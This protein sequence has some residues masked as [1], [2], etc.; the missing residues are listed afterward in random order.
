MLNLVVADRTPPGVFRIIHLQL[1]L[2]MDEKTNIVFEAIT[3]RNIRMNKKPL[4]RFI[5]NSLNSNLL[6]FG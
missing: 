2:I 1:L 3:M 4:S 5:R 6:V